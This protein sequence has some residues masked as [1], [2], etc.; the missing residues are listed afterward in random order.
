M[1]SDL[2]FERY[3]K[4]LNLPEWRK[5]QQMRLKESKILVVG[6]GGLGCGALPFLAAAGVGSITI[7]DADVIELSNLARQVLYKTDAVGA[8]KAFKAAE[9]LQALNP[10]IVI[11]GI[12]E[13]LTADNA[14]S[15][16]AQ[17]DLIIDCTDNFK[18]RYLINDTCVALEKPFVYGAI[19]A[20]EGQFAV[21]HPA[22]PSY[23]SLF[24]VEPSSQ[25]IPACDE[26]GVLGVLP[27]IIGLLQAKEAIFYL[28]GFESPA[29]Q[30]LMTFDLRDMR[31][32]SFRL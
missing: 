1:L 6:A 20:W 3:R 30:G 10:T 7:L 21:F 11:Q 2:E 8:S 4:Q 24:P 19:H 31:L 15:Y 18:T 29:Q 27:G 26:V 5:A 17:Y 16:I 12:A 32:S 14:S 25:E 9:A 13:N 28:A 23:R 22:G